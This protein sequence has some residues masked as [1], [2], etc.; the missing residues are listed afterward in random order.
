[1]VYQEILTMTID[2]KKNQTYFGTTKLF[3]KNLYL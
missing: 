3:Y 1:M 2:Y